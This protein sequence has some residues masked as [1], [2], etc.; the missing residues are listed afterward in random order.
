MAKTY[1]LFSAWILLFIACS[2]EKQT[3]PLLL[4]AESLLEEHPD[5]AL[6]LLQSLPM[7]ELSRK[8]CAR[9]ALILAHATDK[10]EK[11]LFPCDSLLEI[12]LDY[13]DKTEKERATA[14]LYKGRLEIEMDHTKEATHY[15]QEGLEILEDFPKEIETQR[16]ILSSLG[17]LYFDARHYEEANKMYRELY[18][19]C[20]TDKDKSIALN[21]ISPYYCRKNEKDSTFLIQYKALEYAQ[22]SKDSFMIAASLYHLSLEYYEFEELDSA[23]HYARNSIKWLP[24]HKIQGSYYSN[25]GSLLFEKGENKDSAIYYLNK[26]IETNTN[27]GEKATSL[28]SL[29]EIEKERGNYKIAITY[30]EEHVEILDSLFST[31]YSTEIQQLIHEYNTKIRLREEQIKEHHRLQFIIATF[32]FCC[33][34]IVSFYQYH[35]NKRKQA[36]LSYQENLKRTKNELV[37]LQN[38]IKDNQSMIAFI[39][40]EHQ[41]LQKEEVNWL[42]QIQERELIIEKLKQ[43]KENL[44]KWQFAQTD[45]YQKIISLSTQKV[46]NRKEMKVLTTTEQKILM[47]II[48]EIYADYISPLQEKYPRLTA[49]DILYLCL[50]E[51][52]F[53]PLTIALC[54]G[55]HDTHPINQRKLRLKER[56]ECKEKK[57]VTL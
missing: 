53:T 4:K 40:K 39:Q 19:Y 6:Q 23:L 2:L 28:I 37:S 21:D 41:K 43:E 35:I 47:K 13:Y 3:N 20:L 30:L 42:K 15:L 27:I 17:N 38:T 44:R 5:S 22:A 14:L 54:F 56:M 34:L 50:N 48:F 55:F 46:S 32:I 57:D 8:E 7:Q 26:D 33:F 29:Y 9:Y 12:A 51:A 36:Q 24:S 1:L 52:K 45:I 18:K 49:E 11:S 25:L 16:H 10:S 31:E